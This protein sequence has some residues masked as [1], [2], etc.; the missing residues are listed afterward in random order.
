MLFV[1]SYLAVVLLQGVTMRELDPLVK[2]SDIHLRTDQH[3]TL[4]PIHQPFLPL[5]AIGA[6]L[7]LSSAMGSAEAPIKGRKR[8]KSKENGRLR[9]H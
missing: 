7:E 1:L 3:Q 6:C 8:E 4:F 2:S 9:S 5:S